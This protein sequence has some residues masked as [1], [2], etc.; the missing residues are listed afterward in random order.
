MLGLVD[1]TKSYKLG[2]LNIEVLRGISLEVAKGDLLS[3]MGPS[4]SGKSTLMY[5]I[6]LL[7]F[8]Q[9]ARRPLDE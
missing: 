6:G 4:G 5:I 9:R 2:T 8:P 3:I 7:L 1:I